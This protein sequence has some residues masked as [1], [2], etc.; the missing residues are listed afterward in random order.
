MFLGSGDADKGEPAFLFQFV[1]VVVGPLVGQHAVLDPDHRHGGELQ[2]L[3]RVQS[4]QR[5]LPL[6]GIKPVDVRDQCDTFE[7]GQQLVLQRGVGVAA[8]AVGL[9]LDDV[10]LLELLG[11]ADQ[12]AEVVKACAIGVR[13]VV[14][15]VV[16]QA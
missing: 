7:E 15:V 8:I 9:D 2:S 1:F 12:L 5:D 13:L 14:A 10:F 16:F 6:F 4:H 11:S 3:R